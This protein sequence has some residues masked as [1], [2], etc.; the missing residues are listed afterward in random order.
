LSQ[1]RSF[2]TN[3]QQKCSLKECEL[4]KLKSDLNLSLDNL[5]DKQITSVVDFLV[6]CI[7]QAKI[8]LGN[9]H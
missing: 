7:T 9:A 1:K 5:G 3:K 6:I 2:Q 8:K 4:K